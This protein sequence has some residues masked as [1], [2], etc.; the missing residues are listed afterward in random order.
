MALRGHIIGRPSMKNPRLVSIGD[1]MLDVVARPATAVQSGTDTPGTVRLRLGGSAGNTCRAFVA[2]GG[3]ASLVCAVGNDGL[4]KRLIAAHKRE[5]VSVHAVSVRG[6]TPR[7][8]A[9]VAP[10]GE[11]SFVTDRGVADSLPVSGL[12][13][14]WFAH[15]HAIHLPAYSLI[16]EPLSHTALEGVRQVRSHAGLVSVDL[17][18]SG[19]LTAA[20]R[21]YSLHAIRAAAPDVLL[22]NTDEVRALVGGRGGR[23]LLDLA[24]LVVV[25]NG[26]AGCQLVWHSSPGGA[27]QEME[28]ATKPISG[29]DTT[30]AGDAFDAGF[31]YQL[32]VNDFDR[33]APSPA[34]LRRAAL[35]GHRIAARLLL[36]PRPELA[37]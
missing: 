15:A 11:R 4:G 32:L 37:L 6:L 34:L 18:S 13:S 8:L 1:L 23:R 21:D 27:V 29:A 35:A 28:V 10:S 9:M 36:R 31:L 12:K 30:G 33:A 20:G 17:A 2:L 7:L 26:A 16:K 5:G 24:P 14:A 25:K 3:K 22:A 19:P